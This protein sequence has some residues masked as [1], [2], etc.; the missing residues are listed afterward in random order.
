MLQ[1]EFFWWIFL[2]FASMFHTSRWVYMK[3][4]ERKINFLSCNCL[5]SPLGCLS[6]CKWF[7]KAFSCSSLLYTRKKLSKVLSWLRF[8]FQRKMMGCLVFSYRWLFNEATK[9]KKIE[10]TWL[11]IWWKS[12]HSMTHVICYYR[13]FFTTSELWTLEDQEEKITLSAL[14]RLTNF[15][16]GLKLSL[17]ASFPYFY[18]EEKQLYWPRLLPCKNKGTHIWYPWC[19]KHTFTHLQISLPWN[20]IYYTLGQVQF[21]QKEKLTKAQ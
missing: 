7:L 20:T 6:R 8:S 1:N 2:H 5:R 4:S 21:W 11:C 16:P 9:L 12:R 15:S 18:S 10:E 13:D 3:E 17:F 14:Q 19:M